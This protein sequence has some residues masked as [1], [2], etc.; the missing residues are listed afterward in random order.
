MDEYGYFLVTSVVF[1]ELMVDRFNFERNYW[2]WCFIL[3][4]ILRRQQE[5]LH[6]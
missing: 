5:D 6:G 3:A 4:E 1:A 2:L